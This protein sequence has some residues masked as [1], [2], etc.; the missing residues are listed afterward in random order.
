MLKK[1][2]YILILHFRTE[3]SSIVNLIRKKFLK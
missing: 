1:Y 2:N 3:L